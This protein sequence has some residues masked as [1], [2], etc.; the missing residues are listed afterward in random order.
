[1]KRRSLGSVTE[2]VNDFGI[3][4]FGLGIFGIGEAVSVTTDFAPIWQ[5]PQ[6]IRSM[7]KTPVNWQ[8]KI[9]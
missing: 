2:D 5:V 4:T 6:E 1:M 9:E 7:E 3:G 8:E